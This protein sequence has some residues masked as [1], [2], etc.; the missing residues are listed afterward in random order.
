MMKSFVRRLV[1]ILTLGVLWALTA[2][3]QAQA[4][5]PPNATPVFVK[6]AAPN[7]EGGSRTQPYSSQLEGDYVA[8]SIP[9]GAW[10]QFLDAS[11]NPI[12]ASV[13]TPYKVAYFKVVKTGAPLD[14]L[15]LY[16]VLLIVA[17]VMVLFGWG[18]RRRAARVEAGPRGSFGR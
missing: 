16:V 9:G 3:S 8:A 12:P 11:G 17:L 5:I 10:V 7:S 13:A 15:T 14:R 6:T 1:P 18:L 2:S 4:Q